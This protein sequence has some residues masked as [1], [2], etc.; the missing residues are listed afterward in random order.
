[1]KDQR[2]S[3]T[4]VHSK[5]V[6]VMDLVMIPVSVNLSLGSARLTAVGMETSS[7]S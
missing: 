2:F 1:M 7:H 5:E 6:D 4:H 3:V